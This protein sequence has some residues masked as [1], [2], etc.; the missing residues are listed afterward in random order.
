[1]FDRI[2]LG[3]AL[4]VAPFA[5]VNAA[6]PAAPPAAAGAPGAT[7]AAPAALSPSVIDPARLAAAER[8]MAAVWPDDLVL[9]A[10]TAAMAEW[11][12][13]LKGDAGND[14]H[15]AERARLT[16]QA[17]IAEFRRLM[18]EFAPEFRR[19]S[20][21]FYGRKLGLAELDAATRFY[22]SPAGR[23]LVS[24]SLGLIV[25]ADALRGMT[26]PEPDP[27][28]VAEFARLG[29]RIAAET[30]HLLPPPPKPTKQSR[31]ERR[32]AKRAAKAEKE[33][34]GKRKNPDEEELE[35]LAGA[36]A[37]A[38]TEQAAPPPEP[39]D[40]ARL[41]AARRAASAIWPDEAFAQPLPIGD[42][43]KAVSDLPVSAFAP[44][45]PLPGGLGP[46]ASIGQALAAFHPNAPEGML[47]VSRILSEELPR[48]LP[49]AAPFFR[50][51]MSEL[52]A[53]EFSVAEL[54]AI[55]AFHESTPG[56]AFARESFTAMADP[57]F[58]RGSLLMM[59]RLVV[60]GLG[61]M[62]RVGQATAHLPPPPSPPAVTAPEEAGDSD[63]DQAEGGSAKR[64]S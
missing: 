55:S 6:Q 38:D 56:K 29:Q 52:Y 48:V 61:S 30:A 8:L 43:V 57:E 19:L 11:T 2:I 31:A 12:P 50:Q 21:R 44:A 32:E 24:G 63:A 7:P 3:A 40:P 27:E 42:L 49:R 46:H 15:H 53:R 28:L 37:A 22:S 34:R 13:A 18:G 26:Q 62:L 54:E 25:H 9:G 59:P 51:P 1:M 36:V 5:A 10:V 17:M 35:E 60:E 45:V 58:A 16:Q 47:I 33:G 39:A 41:A 4:A 64:G 23:R 20:A 14:P